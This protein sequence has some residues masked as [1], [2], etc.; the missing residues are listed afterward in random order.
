MEARTLLVWRCRHW[1]QRLRRRFLVLVLSLAGGALV[2]LQRPIQVKPYKIQLKA[3][4]DGDA[5]STGTNTSF[6]DWNVTVRSSSDVEEGND[7]DLG[8]DSANR[9]KAGTSPPLHKRMQRRS[10]RHVFT[11]GHSTLFAR[12]APFASLAH[13]LFPDANTSHV[14]SPTFENATPD[15][16]LMWA[17]G[18]RCSSFRM[19]S[20]STLFPGTILTVN[21]EFM[22]RECKLGP[23]RDGI[24]SLDGIGFVTNNSTF[25]AAAKD[26]SRT[27]F[28]YFS[29][30]ELASRPKEQR[31]LIFDPIRREV[32]NTGERFLI[33]ASTRCVQFR[34]EAFYSLSKVGEVYSGGRC[35]GSLATPGGR[36]VGYVDSEARKGDWPDNSVLFRRYRFA[37]VMEN[38]AREGYVTEK[39]VNAFV[40]GAVPI[41]F[42][43]TEVFSLFNPRAFVFYNVSDPQP[44][45]ER[46]AHL[47]ANRTAYLSMRREPI[48][49]PGAIARYYSFHEE[50]PGEGQLKWAI[51]DL[52][53]FG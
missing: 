42:G 51:R 35:N 36:E 19:R 31:Q 25:D 8:T 3:A 49:A 29:A 47:E 43:T 38:S 9:W 20:I 7:A 52:I 4:A 16:V 45:I 12:K 30:L 10:P 2:F 46:I 1:R 53:G 14:D 37:L 32:N 39:L 18:V 48:M 22:A 21:G 13:A 26:A 11:C 15:D 5:N 40:A 44:A 27:V 23:A 34:E 24:Y 50:D 28:T 6:D 41:Y 33:Y 17:C